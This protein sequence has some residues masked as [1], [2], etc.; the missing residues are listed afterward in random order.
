MYERTV[1][2]Q[3]VEEIQNGNGTLLFIAVWMFLTMIG[4]LIAGFGIKG[5]LTAL[6]ELCTRKSE[7]VSEEIRKFSTSLE[8]VNETLRTYVGT[9]FAQNEKI[10]AALVQI[11]DINYHHM[12]LAQDKG[13]DRARD[14][15]PDGGS[16][17]TVA[18]P[19]SENP[20]LR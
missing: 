12:K 11:R 10:I 9:N 2:Q 4:V 1:F 7:E 5:T 3:I 19:S 20:G 15:A 6:S 13:V 17:D 14:N 16:W 8:K 18:R